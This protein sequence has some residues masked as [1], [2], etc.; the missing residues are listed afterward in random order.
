MKKNGEK[1]I[2]IKWI[3]SGKKKHSGKKHSAITE[4]CY[5]QKFS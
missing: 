3:I 5:K 1:K 4:N 2:D